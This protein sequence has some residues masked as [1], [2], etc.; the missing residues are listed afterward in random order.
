MKEEVIWAWDGKM[1]AE[2]FGKQK[3]VNVDAEK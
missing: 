1:L 2:E 3:N